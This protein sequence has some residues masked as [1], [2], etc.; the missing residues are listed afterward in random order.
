MGFRHLS[1]P[2]HGIPDD[3]VTWVDSGRPHQPG[4]VVAVFITPGGPGDKARIHLGDQVV[5]IGPYPIHNALDVAKA[6]WQLP[7]D[8]ETTY[9]LRRNGIE[10]QKDHIFIQAAPGDSAVFYQYA[11]GIAYLVIGFFVYYR[12]TNAQK[13]LQ[14]FVLCLISFIASSFHYSGKL[15][16]FDEL[17]YWGRGCR[18]ICSGGVPPLLPDISRIPAL[19]A[20]ARRVAAALLAFDRAAGPNGGL[21]RWSAPLCN[22]AT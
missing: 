1:D 22:P 8:T 10:F 2:R 5:R 19:D 11:V 15:N 20:K 21:R 16:T 12:P 13:L 18:T 6:L 9:T 17:M 3:G 14:F 4:P 7:L